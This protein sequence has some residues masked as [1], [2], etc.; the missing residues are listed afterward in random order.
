M[1]QPIKMR[2]RSGFSDVTKRM[3]KIDRLD[4]Q[5]LLYSSWDGR[6]Q[7]GIALARVSSVHPAGIRDGYYSVAW[8]DYT[9]DKD[10]DILLFTKGRAESFAAALDYLT[11]EARANIQARQDAALK[12]LL[13]SKGLAGVLV[14]T[15]HARSRS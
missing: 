6:F 8:R 13:A 11:S 12:N 5:Y 2:R 9:H 1:S 7:F 15:D 10:E 4:D 14:Q 3:Y